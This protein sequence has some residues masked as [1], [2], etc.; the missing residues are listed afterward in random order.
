V[1]YVWVPTQQ[2]AQASKRHDRVVALVFVHF[3]V[4]DFL[5]PSERLVNEVELSDAKCR[6]GRKGGRREKRGTDE[7]SF[8]R[9]P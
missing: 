1:N 9:R 2:L 6:E 4:L 5:L 8:A 3:V 7:W